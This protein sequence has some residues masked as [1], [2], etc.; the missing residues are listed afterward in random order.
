MSIP[1]PY[2]VS[3]KTIGMTVKWFWKRVISKVINDV[4]FKYICLEMS[5]WSGF[6]C[7][8]ILAS[9]I[10][11]IFLYKYRLQG[12]LSCFNKP[13]IHLPDRFLNI[14]GSPEWSGTETR[15]VEKQFPSSKIKDLFI[16]HYQ[17]LPGRISYKFNILLFE[18]R[19]ERFGC[20]WFGKCV[21]HSV[22]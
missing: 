8:E 20:F 4:F 12:I 17:P 10:T 2:P 19:S 18:Q 1:F 6:G 5:H 11:K 22:T 3:I 13:R 14:T 15:A 16:W 21:G 9:P 7:R